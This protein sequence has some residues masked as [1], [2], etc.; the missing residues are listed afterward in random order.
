MTPVAH[1]IA[2]VRKALDTDCRCLVC[3]EGSK[4]DVWHSCQSGADR[5]TSH[6]LPIWVYPADSQLVGLPWCRMPVPK[7][8]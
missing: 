8:V 4:G 2:L 1:S 6:T 7:S 3:G 5:E